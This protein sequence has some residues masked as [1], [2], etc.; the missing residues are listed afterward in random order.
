MLPPGSVDAAALKLA[1]R[2]C[3]LEVN[4]AIGGVFTGGVSGPD[5]KLS[6]V[7]VGAVARPRA[8]GVE[9]HA[10]VA[11]GLERRGVVSEPVISH[12]EG[13]AALG[14]PDL[15]LEQGGV[16]ADHLEPGAQHVARAQGERDVGGGDDRLRAREGAR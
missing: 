12:A 10:H 3:V 7:S 15:R 14:P 11:G 13:S 6:T 16:G 4:D 5:W 1:V 2:V 9:H 8:R